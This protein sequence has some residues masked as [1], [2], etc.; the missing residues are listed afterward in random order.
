MSTCHL[1]DVVGEVDEELL[2]GIC[3]DLL[4]E[5]HSCRAGHTFCKECISTWLVRKQTCPIDRETLTAETLTRVRT[6][7]NL[8]QKLPVRCPKHTKCEDDEAVAP[9]AAK[10]PRGS[11]PVSP[12]AEPGCRWTGKLSLRDKHVADD[13]E[14]TEVACG[15]DG[16]QASIARRGLAE[17]EASCT[18]RLVPCEHCGSSCVQRGLKAHVRTCDAVEISCPQKCGERFL[19][20]KN[21]EHAGTCPLVR[22]PCPFAQHGCECEPLRR[23]FD[24]H[25]SEAATEHSLLM[26]AKLLALSSTVAAFGRQ[27]CAVCASSSSAPCAACVHHQHQALESKVL[28]LERSNALQAQ[29]TGGSPGYAKGTLRWTVTGMAAKIAAKEILRTA[30]Y[31]VVGPVAGA[32]TYA[33]GLQ[34]EFSDTHMGAYVTHHTSGCCKY[35]IRLGGTTIEVIGRAREKITMADSDSMDDP[36]RFQEIEP[37][38][39]DFVTLR[40]LQRDYVNADDTIEIEAKIRIAHW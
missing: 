26:N 23:D 38:G 7:E 33:M 5:P 22:L 6:V 37:V 10:R 2:C 3:T 30:G 4:R 34:I 16:C 14:F 9:A 32:G 20:G 27:V 18:Y 36:D 21:G 8:I 25:Q 24:K 13:C 29:A 11:L 31:G 15:L 17:H 12:A 40:S 39:F 28:S 19:R 1:A 35:P